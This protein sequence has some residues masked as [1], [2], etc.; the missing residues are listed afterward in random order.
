MKCDGKVWRGEIQRCKSNNLALW[1]QQLALVEGG[2]ALEGG[3]DCRCDVCGLQISRFKWIYICNYVYTYN[4]KDR[5]EFAKIWE[6]IFRIPGFHKMVMSQADVI[7]SARNKF[8]YG[9]V[10]SKKIFR[11]N[12]ENLPCKEKISVCRIH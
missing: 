8:R 6:S 5:G 10:I 3:E 7:Y 4:K 11:Q 12:L 1:I 2:L 9:E